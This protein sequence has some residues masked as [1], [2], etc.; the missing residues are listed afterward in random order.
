MDD[1]L[2][3]LEAELKRLRPRTPSAPLAAR[4]ARELDSNRGRWRAWWA[5]PVAAALMVALGLHRWSEPPP[6]EKSGEGATAASGTDAGDAMFKPVAVENLL[7]AAHDEGVVTL[8]DGRPARRT[9]RSYVD[10]VVWRDPRSKASLK[11]SVPRSEV[12]VTPISFQ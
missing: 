4:L 2:I 12:V 9:R 10:T 6:V 5:L 11:W 3:S 7:Y 8:A 1:E